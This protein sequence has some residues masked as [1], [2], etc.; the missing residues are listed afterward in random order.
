MD[1][2]NKH[3]DRKN[4]CR[5]SSEFST[6]FS[7]VELMVVIALMG[8]VLV[9]GSRLLSGSRETML[10]AQ[11]ESKLKNTAYLIQKN[12]ERATSSVKWQR[13]H[14][15]RT[16]FSEDE[17]LFQN[18]ENFLSIPGGPIPN[19]W[20][21]PTAPI[22]TLIRADNDNFNAAY[23]G[24]KIKNGKPVTYAVNYDSHTLELFSADDDSA[25][26]VTRGILASRCVPRGDADDALNPGGTIK[27]NEPGTSA[28]Y[29]L[30]D[31]DYRPFPV[32]DSVKETYDIWCCTGLN[33]AGVCLGAD[34]GPALKIDGSLPNGGR[35]DWWVR[36]YVIS[37]DTTNLAKVSSI[38]EI[39]NSEELDPVPQAG[40]FLTFSSAQEP[41]SYKINTFYLNNRCYNSKGIRGSLTPSQCLQFH[42]KLKSPS[43]AMPGTPYYSQHLFWNFWKKSDN[44]INN[45]TGGLTNFGEN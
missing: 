36:S 9:L 44:T 41:F 11:F 2:R 16:F 12:A 3:P 15:A 8:L 14:R 21:L 31:L 38:Y 19:D 29:V 22:T 42:D 34:K 23:M 40:F 39:P 35:I 20:P 17:K 30:K 18:I 32:Y 37:L 28:L 43:V 10:T 5:P 27:T 4:S 7:I 24:G 33:N 6:G 26:Q 25:A 45:V 1:A 13:F